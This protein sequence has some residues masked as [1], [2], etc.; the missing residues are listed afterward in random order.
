MKILGKG[1]NMR[2]VILTGL[3]LFIVAF[4]ISAQNLPSISIVNDT[5]YTIYYIYV[6]SSDSDYWGDDLLG[7]EVLLD[8]ETFTYQL[9]YSLSLVNVYD[10]FLEDEDGDPYF[11]WGL[12]VARNPRIVFTLEDIYLD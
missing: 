4:S 8:G 7:D 11:Q 1:N 9:P 10:I 5:G 6:S 2:K 12:D 3:F